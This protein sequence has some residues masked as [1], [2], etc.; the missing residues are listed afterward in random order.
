MANWGRRGAVSSLVMCLVIGLAFSTTGGNAASAKDPVKVRQAAMKQ[1]GGNLKGVAG[2]LKGGRRA[3]TAETVA[4]RGQ[5]IAAIADRIPAMFPKGTGNDELGKAV[6]R[7]KSAIWEK[8]DAFKSAARTVRKN[9]E[10]LTA[11]AAAGDKAAIGA[12]LKALGKEGCAG[13]HRT[14]RAKRMKK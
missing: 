2:F 7:A 12:A 11:A 5:S 14:F 10:A 13:C 3:G 1:L 8:P 6:T 9:A 4:L